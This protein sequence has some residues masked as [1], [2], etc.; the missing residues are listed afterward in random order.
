MISFREKLVTDE[1]TNEERTDE[2]QWI[3]RTN[4]QSVDPKNNFTFQLIYQTR[5]PQWVRGPH[6]SFP[7]S[8]LPY[9]NRVNSC[10]STYPI[11][12]LV[13]P[14]RLTTDWTWFLVDPYLFYVMTERSTLPTS[15]DWGVNGVP[16]KEN[17]EN[18]INSSQNSFICINV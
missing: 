7:S 3:Y 16:A 17:C 11:L 2:W 5:P 18:A 9:P 14:F 8:G 15:S 10:S 4:L 1:R 6:L 13:G 12:P